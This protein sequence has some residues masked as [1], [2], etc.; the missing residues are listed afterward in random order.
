MKAGHSGIKDAQ[1]LV[2]ECA[3]SIVAFLS[4]QRL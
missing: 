1:P 2:I 3:L 4:G